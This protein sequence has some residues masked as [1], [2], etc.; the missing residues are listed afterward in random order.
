MHLDA[1]RKPVTAGCLRLRIALL[2][3]ERRPSD[4]ARRAHLEAQRRLAA[5][6]LTR[7]RGE[8]TG[9]MVEDSAFDMTVGLQPGRQLGS[10]M[11]RFGNPSSSISFGLY[12][13]YQLLSHIS[14]E[15]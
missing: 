12:F 10:D 13:D 9:P 3:F 8:N 6:K 5:G 7:N 11:L 14:S 1:A 15:R 2:A 4:R